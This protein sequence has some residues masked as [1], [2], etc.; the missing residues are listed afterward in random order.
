[1]LIDPFYHDEP[2]YSDQYSGLVYIKPEI[3]FDPVWLLDEI[4]AVLASAGWTTIDRDESTAKGMVLGPNMAVAVPPTDGRPPAVMT[5]ACSRLYIPDA[6]VATIIGPDGGQQ[7]YI[8]YD[9]FAY[10]DPGTCADGR[11][12]FPAGIT[13][14]DSGIN[15]ASKITDTTQFDVTYT[16]QYVDP[17]TGVVRLTF[18]WKAKPPAAYK[19]DNYTLQMLGS[20]F[21]SKGYYTMQSKTTDQG[22]YLTCKLQL[23]A[24]TPGGNHPDAELGIRTP[25]L[26]IA[27]NG[28]TTQAFQ[29][30]VHA[31]GAYWMS[32]GNHQFVIFPEEGRGG[33]STVIAS[34]PKIDK[35]HPDGADPVFCVG[36]DSYTWQTY[37]SNPLKVQDHMHWEESFAGGYEG[38]LRDVG[39]RTQASGTSL[40][41]DPTML[42]RGL[43]A[44]VPLLT[45][46]N[47]PLIQSA[48]LLSCAEPNLTTQGDRIAGRL[49]DM[50]L[51]S[52]TAGLQVEGG[53]MSRYDNHTWRKLSMATSS[54][55]VNAS[56]WILEK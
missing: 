32:A 34:L 18:D 50:I 1:M 49:W 44:G 51:S 40:W 10:V 55:D 35:E 56:M 14:D 54:G 19:M 12:Y 8:A 42:H 47:A 16:G 30:A 6:V 22:F 37:T 43:R 9:P 33:H 38:V 21:T 4:K 24:W 3:G 53:E 13:L 25:F 31:N 41:R 23:V 5:D 52:S 20:H 27:S 17:T 28:P 15:L 11:T 39:A 45:I 36:S 48:Y 2:A 7:Y 46:W 26:T 29:H